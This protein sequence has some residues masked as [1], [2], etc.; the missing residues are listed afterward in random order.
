[1]STNSWSL[2]PISACQKWQESVYKVVQHSKSIATNISSQRCTTPKQSKPNFNNLHTIP[3]EHKDQPGTDDHKVHLSLVNTRS[4]P[5]KGKE[6]KHYMTEKAIDICAIT[7]TLIHKDP[8]E[9]SLKAVTSEGY[10]ISS[11]PHLDGHR[12]VGIGL[13]NNKESVI[14]SD[15][16]TFKFRE[17]ECSLFKVRVD[18]IQLDQCVLYCYPEGNVLAFFEDLS[19]VLERIVISSHELVILGKFNISTDLQDTTEAITYSDFL[20]LFNLKNHVTFPTHNKNHTLDL[21]LI[22]NECTI[23]GGVT[24][25]DFISDHCSITEHSKITE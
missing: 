24:Q 11:K 22:D 17:E 9:E 8:T 12:G 15:T 13:I 5:S 21:V 23:M 16:R 10:V 3:I 6:L 19:N 20:D 25:G 1:M 2:Y 7:D 14:L 18:H 4:L